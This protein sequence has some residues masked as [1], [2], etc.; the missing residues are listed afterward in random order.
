VAR[1]IVFG[2]IGALG[3]EICR[4]MTKSG[5]DVTVGS[6][7]QNGDGIINTASPDWEIDSAS[8]GRFDSVIWAQGINMAGGALSVSLGDIRQAIDA[9]VIFIVD[10][11]QRLHRAN[12]LAYPARGVIL[13][14]IWQESA[15]DNKL[16]Y[17]VSKSALSGLVP[18]LA[19]D[20]A[21][22]G[23]S[24]N[25]VLPGVIDTPMTRSQLSPEQLS[26]VTGATPGNTLA[27]PEDVARTVAWLA[28]ADSRGINGQSIVVDNGWSIKR[29][30]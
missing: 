8:K 21:S 12:A 16:A 30:V 17:V 25:A 24:V 3:S 27:Q 6:R 20:M 14:S 9:N 4:Y 29:D 15:R 1:A 11:L 28:S 5:W 2:G 22:L 18:A 23:F 7:S 10:S 26:R 19:L 13:S